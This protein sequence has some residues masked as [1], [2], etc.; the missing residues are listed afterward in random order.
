MAVSRVL[1]VVAKEKILPDFA[2]LRFELEVS[3]FVAL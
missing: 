1:A 2:S 3:E